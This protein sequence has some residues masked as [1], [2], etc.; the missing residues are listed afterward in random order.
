M[1]DKDYQKKNLEAI[2]SA[3]TFAPVFKKNPKHS[4]GRYAELIPYISYN[5]IIENKYI[6]RGRPLGEHN[7]FDSEEREIIAE[8]DNIESLVSDGWRLES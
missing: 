5:D 4:L 2:Y 3:A 1:E 8:Y 7:S 6:I